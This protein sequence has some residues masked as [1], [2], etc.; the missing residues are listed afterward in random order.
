MPVSITCACGTQFDA[1]DALAGQETR[2]PE[3]QEVLAVPAANLAPPRTS[4]LALASAILALV[5]AFTVLGTALAALLGLAGLI[6]I[7]RNRE[8][9]AGTGLA[10][11]G[12]VAGLVLTPLTVFALTTGELFGLGSPTR[13]GQFNAEIDTSGPLEVVVIGKGFAITRPSARWGRAHKEI[14]SDPVVNQFLDDP[15]LVLVNPRRYLFVDALV[16][17]D[18]VTFDQAHDEAL[19]A[20]QRNDRIL[21]LFGRGGIRVSVQQESKQKNMNGWKEQSDLMVDVH[22]GSQQWVFLI[23]IQQAADGRVFV[24]RGYTQHRRFAAAEAEL[25]QVLDSFRALDDR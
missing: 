22:C 20:L 1:D 17:I 8:R 3:C 16:A 7:R 23:R 19:I 9:I 6:Q 24:T 18:G 2:C 12:L 11:F 13:M 21:P 15:D 25:R 4:L 10:T 14:L 5:G